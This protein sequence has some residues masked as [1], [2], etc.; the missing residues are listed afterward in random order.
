VIS[1]LITHE[2]GGLLFEPQD[3]E[4]LAAHLLS[5]L[6]STDLRQSHGRL[7]RDIALRRFSIQAMVKG[8]EEVWQRIA[9]P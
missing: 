1:K 5:Y 7:N 8:Y 2:Q 4:M 6:N 3:R 9:A